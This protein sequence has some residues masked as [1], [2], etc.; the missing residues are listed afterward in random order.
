MAYRVPTAGGTAGAGAP[1]AEY[2]RMQAGSAIVSYANLLPLVHAVTFYLFRLLVI[3][4]REFITR[5]PFGS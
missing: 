5:A 3:H 4:D 2:I 1:G